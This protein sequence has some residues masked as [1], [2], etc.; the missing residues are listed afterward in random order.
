MMTKGFYQVIPRILQTKLTLSFFE[1]SNVIDRQGFIVIYQAM[2]EIL[3]T[4]IL[5]SI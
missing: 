1:K 3:I 4:N 5:N 2:E